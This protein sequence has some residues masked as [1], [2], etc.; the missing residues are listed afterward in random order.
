MVN[1]ARRCLLF[2]E[3][4]L[5][6]APPLCVTVST[7]LP[8]DREIEWSLATTAARAPASH[9]AHSLIWA[10]EPHSTRFDLA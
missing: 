2:S 3:L 6:L 1:Y 10:S 4:A 8:P 5:L 9:T 7:T